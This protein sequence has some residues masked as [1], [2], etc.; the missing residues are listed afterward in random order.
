MARARSQSP[1]PGASSGS[2]GRRVLR[3]GP[4]P[5][6]AGP[7]VRPRAE[8]RQGRADPAR[9]KHTGPCQAR[10]AQTGPAVRAGPCRARPGQTHRPWPRR[11]Q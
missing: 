9:D 6:L 8:S 10:S 2:R 11:Q 1:F 4:L 5:A 3:P 7:A